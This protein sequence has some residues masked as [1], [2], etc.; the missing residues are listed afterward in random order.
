MSSTTWLTSV[1]L[2][3]FLSGCAL[4]A[5]V[6]RE[7]SSPA[8]PAPAPLA[9]KPST[10]E[11]PAVAQAAPSPEDPFAAFPDAF[12][13][14]AR[15]EEKQGDLR[16][17][18]LHWR[19]VRAFL[20]GDAEAAG[21][22]TALEREI[23]SQANEHLRKG[24]EQYREGK[25][26]EARR[27]FLAALAYDPYLEEAA[28]YL[29]HR[30]AR[31]D[32]RM[33]VTK[34][35][36][37]PKAVA[38]EVYNDPGKDFLVAYFNGAEG[39]GMYR[40]GTRLTLPLLDIPVAGGTRVSSRANAPI[41][42]YAPAPS[43]RLSP[44]RRVYLGDSLE[45]ARASFLARD[46]KKAAAL[47]E[48]VLEKF[49]DSR[50]ARELSNATYYQLGTEYFRNR[51]YPESLRMFRKVETSYKDQKD[52]VARVE[53]RLREEAESHYMAG[54]KRFLAEDLEGAVKEWETTLKLDPGHPK[55]KKDLERARGMLEQ[56][57]AL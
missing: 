9:R 47:V 5:T 37:T 46:Y 6:R 2:L 16:I 35:G 10:R 34:A 14:K 38:Q 8:P 49:P 24:K 18:L 40:P 22:V 52:M 42:S 54:L 33:Y 45:K 28:D 36:D 11:A 53:S 57:K 32:F 31:Q 27:E 43:T 15:S 41:P 7:P 17:A 56:V 4:P 39:E 21:R 26:E 51:Q 29:K 13:A 20:P 25:Y 12:R 3:L 50:E 44:S 30:L 1:A 19:V 55:A 23:R 48:Q